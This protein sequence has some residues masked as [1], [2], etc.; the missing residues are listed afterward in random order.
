MKS[1]EAVKNSL[2]Q[3]VKKSI[4]AASTTEMDFYE[5][6]NILEKFTEQ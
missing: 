3:Y 2:S 6:K 4:P 1:T 5:I